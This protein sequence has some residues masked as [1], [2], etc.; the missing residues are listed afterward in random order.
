MYTV[1]EQ[2]IEYIL[3]DIRRNGVEMEDLQ[4]NLLD[5]V[6]CIVEQNLKDG[7]D[8]ERFYK[9]TLKEFYKNNLWE[10]EEET[11]TLLTFKNY[12]AMKK[13]MIISGTISAAALLFGSL[14]KVMHWPGASPMYIIGIGTM[15]FIFLPLL[16]FLKTKDAASTRDK[17]V[18]GIGSL[19]GIL[20]CMASLFKVMHWPGASTLWIFVTALSIFIFIPIYFFTG[21]RKPETKVNTM[22]TSFILIGATGLLF[23]LTSL[24][25]SYTMERFNF[26]ANQDL[27]ATYNYLSLENASKYKKLSDS[28]GSGK[29]MTELK[30][31]SSGLCKRI[32]KM[33]LELLN[34]M[35]ERNDTVID[36]KTYSPNYGSLSAIWFDNNGVPTSQL[37]ELKKELQS[38]ISFTKENYNQNCFGIIDTKDSENTKTG[39][40]ISWE[41]INFYM[42][43]YG[44]ALRNLTQLQLDIKIV[45]ATCIR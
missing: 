15:A 1:S 17:L 43:P 32:E 37:A 5:H 40:M 35:E 21:I 42:A 11:I 7:D 16:F 30:E 12:Y 4:L 39:G 23:I 33:K 19:L 9:K 27:A 22:V 31:R 8:F 38:F 25:P 24:K 6:C 10:I 45:E 2:Q 20:L 13:S 18:T 29:M 44:I 36:Y 14:L 41:E 34:N 26:L 28:V 3:N